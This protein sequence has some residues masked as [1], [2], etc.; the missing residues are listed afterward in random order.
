MARIATVDR[1]VLRRVI[2]LRPARHDLVD[3]FY[4]YVRQGTLPTARR[5][6]AQAEATFL[7]LARM[8]GMGTRYEPDEP[9]YAD[10]E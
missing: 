10:R 4:H 3:V 6:L 2:K 1:M 8:P 7:R 5:F 9:L